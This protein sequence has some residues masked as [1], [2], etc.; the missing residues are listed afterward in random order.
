ML[1]DLD[2][3]T[4]FFEQVNPNQ[5]FNLIFPQVSW[6]HKSLI[7]LKKEKTLQQQ[8]SYWVCGNLSLSLGFEIFKEESCL[9][10]KQFES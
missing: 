1:E 3:H 6:M 8:L 2:K 4:T 9:K 5:Q 10:S 7:K